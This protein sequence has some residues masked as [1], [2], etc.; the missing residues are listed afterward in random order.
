MKTG[1]S[2]WSK[3]LILQEKKGGG[4]FEGLKSATLPSC[5]RC[6]APSLLLLFVVSSVFYHYLLPPLHSSESLPILFPQ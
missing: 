4:V 5:P 2:R 1:E 6:A 3:L